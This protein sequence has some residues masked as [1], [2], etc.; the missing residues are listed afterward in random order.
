ML[1]SPKLFLNLLA[2]IQTQLSMKQ[3]LLFP[4]LLI[5]ILSLNFACSEDKEANRQ[6]PPTEKRTPSEP[7]FR[8]DGQLWF[9]SSKGDTLQNITIEVADNEESIQRG[10]MYR[11]KMSYTQGMLFVFPDEAPR[12]FWMKNTQISLDIIFVASN[13]Q[14]VS[15]QKYA[16]P[17]SE[18]SLPSEG[19]A[20][21]VVETKAGFCD[22]YKVQ[23]GDRIAFQLDQ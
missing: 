22:T 16:R 18:E 19:D 14:I 2:K 13:R 6:T 12:S 10:L 15:I 1:F 17:Q 8:Q 20:Q 7:Q 11:S 9:L 21:Y 3:H 5:L 23:A 4:L